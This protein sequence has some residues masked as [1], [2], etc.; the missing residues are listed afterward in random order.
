MPEHE[1]R[2]RA[3][4]DHQADE[5][6]DL[7]R[8]RRP[9]ADW[10]VGEEIFDRL[11]SR[12]FSRTE[13]RHPRRPWHD[14]VHEA[15]EAAQDA[16]AQS[17]AEPKSASEDDAAAAVRRADAAAAERRAASPAAVRRADVA[18]AEPPTAAAPATRPH[19]PRGG[20]DDGRRTIVIGAP[21]DDEADGE[22]PRARQA[23]DGRRTIVI[24]ARS[25]PPQARRRPPRT[26]TERLG[27][28]PDRI[29][30][31]AVALGL[32]LILIAILSA[33]H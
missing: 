30:A 32:L 33:G 11:P 8:R 27:H 15:A 20:V 18:A 9:V 5:T 22:S 1:A 3:V 14:E 31:Y 29:V 16:D 19:I 12:R 17:A 2:F 7:G 21:V 26:A 4:Y 25:Q 23:T 24:G 10:G 13:G 28:R 6:H